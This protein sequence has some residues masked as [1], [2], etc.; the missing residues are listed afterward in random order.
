MKNKNIISDSFAQHF[1]K[2]FK[3][4]N[5]TKVADVRNLLE[6]KVIRKLKPVDIVKIFGSLECKLCIEE[7]V[8]IVKVK[9]FYCSSHKYINRNIEIYRAYQHK[10][11]F[12]TYEHLTIIIKYINGT[13]DW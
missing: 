3:H 11:K 12:Y 13:D 5:K 4:N 8:E 10:V 2:Y 6:V 9:M 1:T 7:R